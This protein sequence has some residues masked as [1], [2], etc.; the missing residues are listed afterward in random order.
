M[1]RLGLSRAE[2][3][4]FVGAV[5]VGVFSPAIQ[6]AD[7]CLSIL[8]PGLGFVLALTPS[9]K[10]HQR[11]HTGGRVTILFVA[12]LVLF[13]GIWWISWEVT[14][15]YDARRAVEALPDLLAEAEEECPEIP[16]RFRGDGAY[17]YAFDCGP[18]IRV[19]ISFGRGFHTTWQAY[20]YDPS[21]SLSIHSR[22]DLAGFRHLM[23]TGYSV[24]CSRRVTEH[25]YHCSVI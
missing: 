18:P 23:T 1:S 3:L 2:L 24:R 14:H 7:F 16:E 17:S 6:S 12:G 4:A 10:A 13:S 9:F 21:D 20:I 25:L 22:S 19:I 15:Y 11:G 5:V 8:V